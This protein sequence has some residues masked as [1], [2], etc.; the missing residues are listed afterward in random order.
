ME[1]VL[2]DGQAKIEDGKP[3]FKDAD[4]VERAIDVPAL[5]QSLKDTADL[6]DRFQSEK[7]AAEGRLA[8]YKDG[9]SYIDPDKARAALALEQ[10][11]DG[12]D[13]TEMQKQLAKVT[14]ERDSLT[15][16]VRA[17]GEERDGL[18]NENNDLTIGSEIRGSA[19]AKEKLIAAYTEHPERLMRE[20]GGHFKREDGRIVAYHETN[21]DSPRP[22]YSPKD[23]AKLASVD[24]ALSV[25]VT[26][27]TLFK[28]DGASGG[29]SHPNSPP[30]SPPPKDKKWSEMTTAEQAA[31]VKAESG[32]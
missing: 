16:Q 20:Y 19:W 5:H 7:K 28:P 21:G 13:V 32:Q 31:T 4:G 17:L 30:G 1:L 25:L 18:R 8:K 2:V 27:K 3:V 11:L 14:G 12:K 24:E 6:R 15:E 29:G 26:D 10:T 9:D 22:I 23:P